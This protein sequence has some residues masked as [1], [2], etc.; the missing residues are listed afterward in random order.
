MSN[1]LEIARWL[2]EEKDIAIENVIVLLTPYL[3]STA[4]GYNRAKV[5][6][7]GKLYRR[8]PTLTAR[9]A[10]WAKTNTAIFGRV[11]NAVRNVM[12]FEQDNSMLLNFFDTGERDKQRASNLLE[13]LREIRDWTDSID[14]SLEIVYT[15][16]ALELDFAGVA[17]LAAQT[18][19]SVDAGLPSRQTLDVAEKLGL[20]LLDLRPALSNILAAGK[21][22]TCR[23]DPH[24]NEETSFACARMIWNSLEPTSAD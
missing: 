23:G 11:R 19:Q 14:A 24:Y 4:G 20:P 17:M 7:D 12:G 6:S 5:S 21:P 16:L 3:I 22:L 8:E 13:V 1:Q 18:S 2:Y 9:L 10:V 15:P